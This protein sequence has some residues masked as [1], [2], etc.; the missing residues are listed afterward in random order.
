MHRTFLRCAAV[1][2]FAF[3][4]LATALGATIISDG[5]NLVVNEMTVLTLKSRSVDGTTPEDR[6]L[7]LSSNLIS[8]PYLG[9]IKI[10]KVGDTHA[11]FVGGVKV[12]TITPAEA[13][14]HR[15]TTAALAVNW[16]TKLRAA[17]AMPPLKISETFLKLPAPSS[18]FVKMTGFLA[19]R[20]EV[21]S[22]DPNIASV[23]RKD[24]GFEIQANSSGDATIMI[25]AGSTQAQIAIEVR[26]YAAVFP[27]TLSGAVAGSPALASTV[28]GAIR[29]ALKTQ[30]QAVPGAVSTIK[31]IEPTTLADGASRTYEVKLQVDSNGAFSRAGTVNVI[32]RNV[33]LG[34]RNDTELWY[35]NDPE[36]IRQAGPLFSATLRKDAPARLLYHHINDS[37]YPL[38]LRVQVI[39]DSDLP[40]RVMVIPGDSD[41]D[42][43]PVRAGL[44]AASQYFRAWTAYSGEVVTI[45]PRYTMPISLRRLAPKETASGLCSLRL[46]DGPNT[47]L[48]RTD[49]W[50]PF[51]LDPRWTE[52]IGS[53]TPWREVGMNPIN[54]Y[55]RAP[56]EFSAHIYPNPFKE[57]DVV[58]NVGGRY[59]F[60]RIGQRPIQRSDRTRVLDG[61]F[62]VVYNIKADVNNRSAE[63]TDIEIV[64]EAS[65]GYSGALFMVDGQYVETPLLQPKAEYQIV[66]FR[67]APGVTKKLDI[68]TI[69][70]SGSSY[71]ATITVRPV[72]ELSRGV[73]KN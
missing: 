68:F 25:N 59:G 17:L 55:D 48:V 58:Y 52:A 33:P 56:S 60:V 72:Q 42:K 14:A 40:A 63:A 39:N 32:V 67:L 11:L 51:N 41:P 43:N 45:P 53:T 65:A 62:G 35:C 57:E 8:A 50:P 10:R 61:N 37:S 46:I 69:P 12:L 30:F 7:I 4:F 27:Q 26:P 70:L 20:A 49:A 73:A 66:R 19:A 21:T 47:L 29:G 54:D 18:K 64:F 38:Y 24:G 22:T 71:P 23:L 3:T 36:N 31:S 28:E 6:A 13:K 34:A 1:V 15:S 2:A 44:R 9:D 16:S 5:P